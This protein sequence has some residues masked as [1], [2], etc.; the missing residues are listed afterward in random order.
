MH[1]RKGCLAV[2]LGGNF[3]ADVAG[4]GAAGRAR[5]EADG[6]RNVYFP[7]QQGCYNNDEGYQGF[8]FPVEEGHRTSLNDSGQFVYSR[9]FYFERVDFARRIYRKEQCDY[10]YSSYNG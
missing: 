10:S 9:V 7:R 5:Y 1:R 6:A 3:H 2:R 4:E 8:I